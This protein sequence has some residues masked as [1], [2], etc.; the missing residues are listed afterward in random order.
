MIILASSI[1]IRVNSRF[2]GGSLGGGQVKAILLGSRN[3]AEMR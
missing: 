3:H 2:F 1:K